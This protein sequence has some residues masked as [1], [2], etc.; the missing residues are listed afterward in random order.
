[1]L[2]KV[3]E[4]AYISEWQPSSCTFAPHA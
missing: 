2:E 1:M 4:G 3:R